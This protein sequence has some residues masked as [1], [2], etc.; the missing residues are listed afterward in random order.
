[1]PSATLRSFAPRAMV[2][3]RTPRSQPLA[4]PPSGR[5]CS[6][7]DGKDPLA[8]GRA[9]QAQAG[10]AQDLLAEECDCHGLAGAAV[11]QPLGHGRGI[12]LMLVDRHDFVP[13]GQSCPPSRRI[14]NH[15]LDH[16]GLARSEAESGP[17]LLPARLHPVLAFCLRRRAGLASKPARRSQEGTGSSAVPSMKREKYQPSEPRP[18]DSAAARM[19]SAVMDR[20]RRPWLC[21]RRRNTWGKSAP[22]LGRLPKHEVQQ[23]GR[24]TCPFRSS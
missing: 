24:P 21:H 17:A 6:G 9:H 14:R 13:E 10:R 23:Q 15:V 22:A 19:S 20:P 18:T 8:F 12:D 11:R 7:I 1:M 3:A 2:R 4:H 5:R 16:R